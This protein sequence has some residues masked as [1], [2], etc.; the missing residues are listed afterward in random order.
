MN[1]LWS[2]LCWYHLIAFHVSNDFYI[3]LAN[4]TYWRMRLF[5]YYSCRPRHG[6]D[7][8]G[9]EGQLMR[10]LKLVSC[11][12][13]KILRPKVN[14]LWGT[15]LRLPTLLHNSINMY[16]L[17]VKARYGANYVCDMREIKWIDGI[18]KRFAACAKEFDTI[19]L[20]LDCS[21]KSMQSSLDWFVTELSSVVAGL[22]TVTSW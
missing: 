3:I 8:A 21:K 10:R 20:S 6:E 1:L 19:I 5:L 2:T 14:D 15:R 13:N 4:Q 11:R 18:E 17:I 7:R 22:S 9:V 16:S 12:T